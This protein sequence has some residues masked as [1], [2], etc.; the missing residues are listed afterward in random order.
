MVAP[1]EE[2]DSEVA[3]EEVAVV[4]SVLVVAVLV[5]AVVVEVVEVVVVPVVVDTEKP[6]TT[7][8]LGA[9]KASTCAVATVAVGQIFELPPS[10]VAVVGGV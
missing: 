6:G 5:V 2:E 10:Q 8:R 1:V 9:S 7:L 3:V 4:V